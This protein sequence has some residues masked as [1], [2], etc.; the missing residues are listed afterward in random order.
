MYL[1]IYILACFRTSQILSRR[2]GSMKR[3][4]Y[5]VVLFLA[6]GLIFNAGFYGCKKNKNSTKESVSEE[7]EKEH[8]AVETKDDADEAPDE[9]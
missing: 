3:F 4:V 9:E 6:V 8:N 2:N 1:Y 7:V 5:L